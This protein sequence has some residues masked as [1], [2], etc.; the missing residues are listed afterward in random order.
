MVGQVRL[1]LKSL[2]GRAARAGRHARRNQRKRCIKSASLTYI[3]TAYLD[4]HYLPFDVFTVAATLRTQASASCLPEKNK[5]HIHHTYQLYMGE[6]M[7]MEYQPQVTEIQRKQ[8]CNFSVPASPSAGNL[9]VVE[10]A[11]AAYCEWAQT[12][13]NQLE[14]SI[15]FSHDVYISTPYSLPD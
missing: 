6:K 9:A 15:N 14:R 4:S 10:E 2:A 5:H 8:V 3:S 1:Y 12:E 13:R 11:G 7:R